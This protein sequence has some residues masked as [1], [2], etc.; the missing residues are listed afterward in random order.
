MFD[1]V[2]HT[3]LGVTFGPNVSV[4]RCA[5]IAMYPYTLNGVNNYHSGACFSSD[6][7]FDSK[8]CYHAIH[9]PVGRR[10]TE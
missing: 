9:R 3:L 5:S 7:G 1:F 10:G 8:L 4:H 2:Q 6:L